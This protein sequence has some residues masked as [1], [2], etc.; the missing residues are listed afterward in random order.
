MNQIK[1]QRAINRMILYAVMASIVAAIA[2][3][4]V[5]KLS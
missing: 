1:K 3:V 2:V 5:F 4:V